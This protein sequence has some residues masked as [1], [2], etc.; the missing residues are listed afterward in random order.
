MSR[1][2]VF[3]LWMGLRVSCLSSGLFFLFF[4]YINS[5]PNASVSKDINE[6]MFMG[7]QQ[8]CKSYVLVY[9]LSI[10]PSFSS[11]FSNQQP[12]LAIGNTQPIL[13]WVLHTH[14]KTNK[15]HEPPVLLQKLYKKAH[16]ERKQS[17]RREREDQQWDCSEL[18]P[19]T[20]SIQTDDGAIFA[21]LLLCSDLKCEIGF[22]I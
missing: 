18:R 16:A 19:G 7:E 14:T 3:G 9:H 15:K 12:L 20:G 13:H 17:G 11:S 22:L 8:Q 10:H 2:G 5:V 4:C 1:T 21:V 6:F